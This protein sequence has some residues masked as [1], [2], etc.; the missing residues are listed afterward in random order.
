MGEAPPPPDEHLR[1]QSL[2][3]LN[4]VET[5]L[6]ERFERIT[7]LAQR[8]LQ[9]P[10]AAI[11]LI[12]ADRQWFKSIQGLNISETSRAV[13]FC[14]HTILHDAP[15]IVS[16]ARSDPRF[17]ENPLVSGAPHIV[18]YAGCPIR[19]VDGNKVASLCVIDHRPRELSAEDAQILRDLAAVAEVEFF[20]SM[21]SSVQQ[22]LIAQV[23]A[24]AK[25]ARIDPLTRIW[26]RS[27]I[28]ELLHAELSRARRTHTGMGILMAD[29]DHFKK[30]NDTHGHPAGDEVLR[31]AAKRM[32]SAIR[33]GDAL[34]RY[35]GEEFMIVLGGCESIE[36][37]RRVA[38]RIRERVAESPFRTDFG[39]VSVTLSLGMAFDECP[40]HIDE[41][42]LL[43][44]ADG[45][46]YRAKQGGRNRVETTPVVAVPGKSVRAA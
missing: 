28:F 4:L 34:G 20:I 46:L 40:L 7:R 6:E 17:S 39:D 18:F 44:I 35:G 8:V 5:P 36:A 45:A 1:L 22:E 10:I 27:S 26:N 29:I 15:L 37:G 3:A 25:Q 21:Q 9:A 11:S 24:A 41:P 2:R 42:T 13:S 43:Q 32:L 19:S 33:E 31:Q 12:E 16:D 14:S 30:I 23:D 38:E